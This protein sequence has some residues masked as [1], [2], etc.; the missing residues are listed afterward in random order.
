MRAAIDAAVEPLATKVELQEVRTEVLT[1][2]ADSEQRMR[3]HF[4]VVTESLRDDIRLI[5]TAFDSLA[6]RER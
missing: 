1:R 3:T 6:R 5:A 2:I 4:D